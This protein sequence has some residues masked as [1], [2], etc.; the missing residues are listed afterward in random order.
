MN[1][2]A[3]TGGAPAH[4]GPTQFLTF[5]LG[6]EMF[7]MG[8]LAVKEI[9]EYSGVTEVPQMPA[10]ISGVINLR[11]AAVPVMDLARR[12][13]R[14]PSALTKRSCI[15]VVE[16]GSD[17]ERLVIGVLVDAV[18]AVLDIPAADIEPPPSFGAKVRADLLVGIGK[19]AGQF[20]LL[21]DVAPVVSS[22]EIATLAV[23]VPELEAELS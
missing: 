13:E 7:A 9:I 8:I 21:L 10:C 1:E 6:A 4:R 2:L 15:I 11:G 14:K 5:M 22:A 19:V 3:T 23:A 12:L 18:N 20:V 17:D 16:A